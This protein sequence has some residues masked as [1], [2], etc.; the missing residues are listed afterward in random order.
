MLDRDVLVLAVVVVVVLRDVVLRNVVLEV[1]VLV[2]AASDLGGALHSI[3]EQRLHI[4]TN[5]QRHCH[6]RHQ[7]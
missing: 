2:A 4:T 5:Q 6:K 7:D 3:I 1:G